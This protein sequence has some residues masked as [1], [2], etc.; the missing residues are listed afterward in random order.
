MIDELTEWIEEYLS[1]AKGLERLNIRFYPQLSTVPCQDLDFSNMVTSI[2]AAS[3][4]L[5]YVIITF[6]SYKAKYVCKRLQGETWY[7]AND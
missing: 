4:R 7:I 6:S 3:T 1:H 2:F 5:S